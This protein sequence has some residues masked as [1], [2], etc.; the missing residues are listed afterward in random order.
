VVVGNVRGALGWTV[1]TD[2]DLGV[3]DSTAIWFTQFHWS[4]EVRVIDYYE[5]NRS[6]LEAMAA[7]KKS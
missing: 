4:G 3:G 5:N 7:E 6:P 2:W 1:D